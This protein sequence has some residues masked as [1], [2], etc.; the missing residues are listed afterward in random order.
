MLLSRAETSQ[1]LVSLRYERNMHTQRG[2]EEMANNERSREIYTE[3]LLWA[4]N[5]CE[6]NE[7]GVDDRTAFNDFDALARSKTVRH[8]NTVR[9][10]VQ[11]KTV[12]QTRQYVV[13]CEFPLLVNDYFHNFE[14]SKLVKNLCLLQDFQISFNTERMSSLYANI[15]KSYCRL[16]DSYESL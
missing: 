15:V 11:I 12:N 7:L 5:E 10:N 13:H 2:A 16:L 4:L 3:N 8:P 6:A 1:R 14:N 9:P